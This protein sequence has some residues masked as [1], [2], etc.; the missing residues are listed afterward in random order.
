MKT[1]MEPKWQADVRKMMADYAE[2]P[3]MADAA[4]LLERMERAAAEAR[5]RRMVA[6]W[7]RRLA[8][9]A[10]AAAIVLPATRTLLP[11]RPRPARTDALAQQL[12]ARPSADVAYL[13]T[14]RPATAA[15]AAA[16]PACAAPAPCADTTEAQS[17]T[18]VTAPARQA[19]S[20][21]AAPQ[22]G[23][24]GGGR[25][26]AAAGEGRGN[27][28]RL[29]AAISVSGALTGAEPST[30]SQTAMLREADPIGPY[31][32]TMDGAYTQDTPAHSTPARTHTHHRQPLRL[33]LTA[34]YRISPRWAVEAGLAYS[35]LRS[36][37]ETEGANYSI[38]TSQRLHYIGLPV[39]A[40]Y[41]AW[42]NR[43]LSLYAKAGAMAEKMV[44]GR[45][46]TSTTVGGESSTGRSRHVA[47]GPLQLSATAAL[48]AEWHFANGLGLYAE[49][50]IT[51][52]FDSGSDV[53]TFYSD[54][55]V[56]FSLTL[57]LRVSKSKEAKR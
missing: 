23:A 24:R 56:A 41:T 25:L 49:P 28:S 50:G 12:V 15:V 40:I 39:A 29:L 14:R 9:A 10:V 7:T 44:G 45:A 48:G 52:H 55:P 18:P 1:P 31:P 17:A 54:N 32:S 38:T 47:I 16:R 11:D 36:E 4:A 34:A 37:T 53:S 5:R 27:G 2:K 19:R 22:A 3:P 43:R 42:G 33:A 57:G 8:A 51:Y 30:L 46:Q 35:Y 26:L 6:L 13:P 21:P 20:L